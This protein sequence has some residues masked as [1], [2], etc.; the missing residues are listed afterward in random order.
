MKIALIVSLWVDS[1]S[2]GFF[3]FVCLKAVILVLDL[4]GLVFAF[5][6]V[7][8]AFSVIKCFGAVES[9]DSR[10]VLCWGKKKKTHRILVKPIESCK[11]PPGLLDSFQRS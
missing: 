7:L 1:V 3:L 5:K 2:L 6:P 10:V 4:K 9:F 11:I 8:L